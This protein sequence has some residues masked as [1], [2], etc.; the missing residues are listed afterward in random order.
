M[1]VATGSQSD[2]GYVAE[3]A[4]GVM[5]STPQFKRIRHTKS[6]LGVQKETYTSD[7]KRTDRMTAD[8]RHGIV[9]V[10]GDIE[11][12]LSVK[13]FDD[14]IEALMGNTWENGISHDEND[15]TDISAVG[16]TK[17]FTVGAPGA[18][19]IADGYKIGDVVK[20]SG[21][22]VNTGVFTIAN[23]TDN[24]FTVNETVVN[25]SSETT[26]T[27]EV[28]GKKLK[29]GNTYRS[30]SIER[31]FRDVVK[32]QVNKG[33]RINSMNMNIPATGITKA[34]FGIIGQDQTPMSNT[35]A[36]TN[37]VYTPSDTTSPL[38]S[39][40][41]EL[42]EG[43]Q[44]MATVTGLTL[45]INNQLD[46]KATLGS[47]YIQNVLWGKMQKVSG[48]L[49]VLFEDATMYNK[50]INETESS[51]DLKLEDGD[52]F[53]KIRLPRVKYTSGEIGD[54]DPQGL[55]I[56]MN[57]EALVPSALTDD[58]SAVVFQEF[59]I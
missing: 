51:I 7:E 50:F 45:N 54:D 20:L 55:P 16:S 40:K 52:N 17:V 12:E 35:S 38:I 44:L 4:Y 27:L 59:F 53:M 9:K 1:T 43:N 3:V 6:S 23:L 29:I 46:G 47:N 31:A 49:T 5:P 11:T 2:L 58:A 56:Q 33:C 48:E 15:Y 10:S 36:D 24:T 41:G 30:F 39:V 25:M 8:V 26:F 57:F 19:L 42:R 37:S 22:S 28:L 34:T 14:F 13:S 21:T 18:D 32:F